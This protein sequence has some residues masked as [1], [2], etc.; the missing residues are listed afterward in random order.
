MLRD[1]VKT[2]HRVYGWRTGEGFGV[3]HAGNGKHGKAAIL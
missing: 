1:Y 2:F 3:K